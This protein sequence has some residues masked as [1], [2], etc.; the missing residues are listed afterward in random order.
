MVSKLSVE[1][2]QVVQSG[3]LEGEGDLIVHLIRFSSSEVIM[4]FQMR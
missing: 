4:S 2:I 1:V 3:H